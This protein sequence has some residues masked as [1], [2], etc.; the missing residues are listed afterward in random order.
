MSVKPGF[1]ARVT[2]AAAIAALVAGSAADAAQVVL[3]YRV[4]SLGV[5]G[6][7]ATAFAKAVAA[8]YADPRGWS[9]GGAVEFRRVESGG[10]F[11]IWLAAAQRMPSFSAD[12][13][14]RWSCRVG[15][16]VVINETRW[17]SGSPDWPGALGDYRIMLVNH[18]TGHWLGLDHEP[19]PG[20]GLPAPV[21]MQQ[22]KGV[23]PCLPNPWPLPHERRHVASLL[24]VKMPARP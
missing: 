6:P 20:P 3:T 21:M 10:S 8:A 14:E 22:S 19:C 12:C 11:T 4:E 1:S 16:D 18:E 17:T 15:R 7:Q 24:G 13:S 23:N 9:L 2:I 5:P